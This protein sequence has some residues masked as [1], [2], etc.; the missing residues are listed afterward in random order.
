MS[1]VPFTISRES[2]CLVA[3]CLL[4]TLLTILFVALGIATEANPLMRFWLEHGYVAFA[5][6]K[7]GTLVPVILLAERHRRRNPIF[8]TRVLRL[9]IVAYLGIYLVALVT[10]NIA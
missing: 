8:V 7:M 1:K 6:V 9:G 3:I 5:L 2:S 4:D 10:V